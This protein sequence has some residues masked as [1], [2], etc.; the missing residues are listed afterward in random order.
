MLIK[1]DGGPGRTH[2]DYLA[3]SNLDGLVHYPGLPN[4]TYFQEL[5]QIFAYLKTIM[6]ENR[7]RIWDIK[8][9]IDGHRA[10]V[11]ICDFAKILFGGKYSFTTGASINLRNAFVEGLSKNH[12]D[13]AIVKCGYV[14]ATRAALESKKLR[15]EIVTDVDGELDEDLNNMSM[16][17]ALLQLEKMNHEVIVELEDKGYKLASTLK[18][19]V[20]RRKNQAQSSNSNRSSGNNEL[21]VPGTSE[22]QRALA[23]ATTQGK[24]YQVTN[25]GAPMNSDDWICAAELKAWDV[26]KKE[27]EKK[28]KFVKKQRK[29]KMTASKAQGDNPNRWSV[30]AL[31]AKFLEKDPTLKTTFFSSLKKPDLLI[32]WIDDYS[33]RDDMQGKDCC[34]TKKEQKLLQLLEKGQILSYD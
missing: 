23:Q 11:S 20:N 3:Q 6:E 21:T 2:Q 24:H 19:H 1:S 5:D 30:P 34:F 29:I 13:R 12:L 18:R 33:K 8:F 17:D 25:G 22:H 15:H 28:K 10:K 4:G 9:E 32:L 27:I 26:R 14:P 7:K 31:R 16:T